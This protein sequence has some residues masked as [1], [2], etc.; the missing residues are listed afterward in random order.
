MKMHKTHRGANS[1]GRDVDECPDPPAC[2]RGE[3]TEE[4]APV[5]SVAPDDETTIL[6]PCRARK[7][8]PLKRRRA[9]SEEAL[10]RR[11]ATRLRGRPAVQKEW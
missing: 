5:T 3:C 10:A 4:L 1:V 11:A 7:H 6:T 2:L 9:H 8:S